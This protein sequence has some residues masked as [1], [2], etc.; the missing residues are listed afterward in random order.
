MTDFPYKIDEKQLNLLVKKLLKNIRG[1]KPRHHSYPGF[2]KTIKNGIRVELRYDSGGDDETGYD[3]GGYRIDLYHRN[4]K[5][6]MTSNWKKY[7]DEAI[8]K[9]YYA[10]IRQE[11]CNEEERERQKQKKNK[12][13]NQELGDLLD[14]I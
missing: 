1:W 8:S 9:L 13:A 2:S 4:G 3:P 11:K 10:L 5:P 7:N 6:Y 14:S 12:L